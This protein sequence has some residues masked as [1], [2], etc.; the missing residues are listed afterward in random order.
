MKVEELIEK[1]KELKKELGNVD[2][3]VIIEDIDGTETGFLPINE[4][5]ISKDENGNNA[6]IYLG[7][8]WENEE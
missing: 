8:L 4:V 6:G 5:N 3:D 7:Y 1:L 2:V